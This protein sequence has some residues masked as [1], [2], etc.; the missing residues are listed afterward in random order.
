MNITA[1]NVYLLLARE[2]STDAADQMNSIIKIIDKFTFG[3]NVEQLSK[4][5]RQVGENQIALP[6]NYAAATAWL[7]GKKLEEDTLLNFKVVIIDPKGKNLGGPEQEN[8]IPAGRSKVSVNFGMQ[9]LPVTG[10]GTYTLHAEIAT[11]DG[12]ILAKN[13]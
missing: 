11:K 12:K 6:A 2:V 4:A 10:D 7:L 1:R 13:D 5:N 9:G 8:M 3:V